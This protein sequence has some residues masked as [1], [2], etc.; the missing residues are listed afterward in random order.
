MESFIL[1]LRYLFIYLFLLCRLSVFA[2]NYLLNGKI[3]DSNGNAVEAAYIEVQKDSI[4]VIGYGLSDTLGYFTIEV[5]LNQSYQINIS[6]VA[7]HPIR[8]N[9]VPTNKEHLFIMKERMESIDEVVITAYKKGMKINT[10]GNIV[11][12]PRTLGNTITYNLTRLLQTLPSIQVSSGGISL[13]GRPTALLIN[14]HKRTL[15]GKSIEAF[16]QSI[17]TDKIKEIIVTPV[18]SASNLA[19][20]NGSINI[21][22]EKGED[23]IA[24][25]ISSE[26]NMRKGG[27]YGNG[28]AF[29]MY[30][31][32]NFYMDLSL[33]Y[34]N[35]Y[36][37]KTT[38]EESVYANSSA[39][40][41]F[42]YNTDS[43]E[44]DYLGSLNLEWKTKQG[45]KFFGAA[46]GFYD[47]G[48]SNAKNA[49][50]FH[51]DE[52]QREH[53]QGI[54][55]QNYDDDL[56]T[57]EME[58]T[59]NDTLRHQHTIGYG[60][61]WGK[62]HN[63]GINS[64]VTDDYGDISE[65]Q[66]NTINRHYGSQHQMKYNYKLLINTSSTLKA[67]SHFSIGNINPKSQF[68]EKEIM[69][70][71]FLYSDQYK[72]HENVYGGFVEY[73][74]KNKNIFMSVGLRL[75][76]TDFSTISRMN[77]QEYI[78]N[79]MDYFPFFSI[80]HKFSSVADISLRLASGIERPHFLDYVPN[81]RYIS[82]YAYSIGNPDLKPSR[83]Y[84]ATVGGLLFDFLYLELT[85][86]HTKD[87]ISPISKNEANSFEE[88]TTPL[89][90]SDENRFVFQ[91]SCPYVLLNNKLSGY[92]GTWLGYAKY[93]NLKIDLGEFYNMDLKGFYLTN[94]TQ[95]E[96]LDNLNIGYDLYY[97]P[98]LYLQQ[99]IGDPY[100]KLG[101]DV[102][103]RIK[104]F[105]IG[106]NVS[107]ILNRMNKG[108][109]L[110]DQAYTRYT[111]NKNQPIYSLTVKYNLGNT[112]KRKYHE[113]IDS[114]R[115]K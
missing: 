106:F 20:E 85:Y 52:Q 5:P 17:P 70:E 61:I 7:F 99:A 40:S 3:V 105:D 96:V 22:L 25:Q 111:I 57:V 67:G 46:T 26:L 88:V 93:T 53:T 9:I 8:E 91:M 23:L 1:R 31:K 55:T 47:N 44:N 50:I 54:A 112:N 15:N 94:Q 103:Y 78:Y 65:L 37:R 82:K 33:G 95:Y 79:R 114:S 81:Y 38:R 115:F 51:I 42:D 100:F 101:F 13:N 16:L 19:S 107:N 87:I 97:Q 28:N 12:S 30:N 84:S 73:D 63:N 56:Y 71:D 74:Y 18:S 59:S 66:H 21:I 76:Y 32:N 68:I 77:S 80:K 86:L 14:G 109:D 90:S 29:L 35:I 62:A 45:H 2:D 58:F 104:R 108:V 69:N 10:E 75:E 48:R 43:R 64:E 83:F 6:H 36:D 39:S 4:H 113:I 110:N 98:K 11:F 49:M 92:L 24:T 27:V 89:N 72:M 60:V 34:Y 102:S 41:L